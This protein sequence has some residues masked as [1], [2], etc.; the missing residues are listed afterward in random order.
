MRDEI[1][2]TRARI[3]LH[4][5]HSLLPHHQETCS[6]MQ[7]MQ[8]ES[9]NRPHFNDMSKI[10]QSTENLQKLIIPPSRSQRRQH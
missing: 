6:S 7:Y 1:I 3:G 10:H 5:P 8:R 4:T 2:I 9:I